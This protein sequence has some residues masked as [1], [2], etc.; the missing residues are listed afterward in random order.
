V[1]DQPEP[2]ATGAKH[3]RHWTPDDDLLAGFDRTGRPRRLR[4]F[5]AT[6]L[7]ASLLIWNLAFPLGAYHTV[8]YSRLFQIFVGSTVLLVGSI[9]L[10]H[11]VKVRPWTR[12]LLAIPAVWLVVHTIAPLGQFSRPG[13]VLDDILVGFVLVSV[14]FTLWVVARVMAPEYF[15]LHERRL[16]SV[17][18]AIVVLVGVTGVLVGQFNYRFTT[19][20]S[21]I[22]AGDYT[23]TN[24]KQSPSPSPAPPS[25][26]SS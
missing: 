25:P 20:H 1:T 16:T 15:G 2:P 21:Y 18:V 12:P 3:P 7:G 10:R 8:F 24:C 14:P 5:F 26:H 4:T 22:V 19:C 9:A 11:D 13:H 17:A 6:T 23:P